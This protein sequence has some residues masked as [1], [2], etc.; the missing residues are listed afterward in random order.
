MGN[1]EV[2]Q[3][4]HFIINE[5]TV[6]YGDAESREVLSWLVGRNTIIKF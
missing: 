1:K 4:R 3:A 6:A 5:R 2:E